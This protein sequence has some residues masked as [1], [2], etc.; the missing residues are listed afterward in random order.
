MNQDINWGYYGI[1]IKSNLFLKWADDLAHSFN[2]HS[3][4]FFYSI[5][6]VK[7][8]KI[9]CKQLTNLLYDRDL[10]NLLS[11]LIFI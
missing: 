11:Q 4:S 9:Y 8:I 7:K 1:L 5:A 3:W 2:F 10:I 6:R